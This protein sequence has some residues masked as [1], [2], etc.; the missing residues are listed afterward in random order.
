MFICYSII[1]ISSLISS[2]IYH[3]FI[4]TT[5]AFENRTNIK[6][7][8]LNE[9][10]ISIIQNIRNLLE[11]LSDTYKTENYQK[12]SELAITAYIDN[13]EYIETP[14]EITG[15]GDLMKEIE[16]KMRVD[17]REAIKEKESQSEIDKLIDYINTKLFDVAII[18]DPR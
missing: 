15:N 16:L 2:T 14:L 13:Y 6:N 7:N 18:L 10:H 4:K 9:K 12:A 8:K 11:Q 5:F 17:L 3:L 1:F